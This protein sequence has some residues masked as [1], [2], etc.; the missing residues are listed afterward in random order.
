MDISPEI[1]L[2]AY[3]QHQ[4]EDAFRELVASTL[5]EV[6]S[7]SLRIAQGTPHLAEEIAVKVYLELSRKARWLCKDVVLASWLRERTCKMAVTVLHAADRPIDRAAMKKEKKK[8]L[9]TPISVDPAPAGLAIR[10]CYNVFLNTARHKGLGLYLPRPSWPAW[11]RPRHIVGVVACV[12]AI[13]VWRNNPFHR[14]NPIVKSQGVLLTPSSFA[15]RGS[16]EDGAPST[17]KD[18][19]STNGGINSK[20]K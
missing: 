20:Q 12:L 7:T 10:I 5:D 11:I 8:A 19:A 16:P 9:S 18:V 3:V 17:R 4:S 15:Q 1:L 14:H 6:Y 2:K 13:L